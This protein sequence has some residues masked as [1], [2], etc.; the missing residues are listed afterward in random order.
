MT[1]PVGGGIGD[2]LCAVDQTLTFCNSQRKVTI[3]GK[4]QVLKGGDLMIVPTRPQHTFLNNITS[5]LF[6]TRK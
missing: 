5:E 4:N 6:M 1:I 3:N 2:E